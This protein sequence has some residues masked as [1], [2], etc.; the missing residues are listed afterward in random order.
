MSD[1]IQ[2]KSSL[3]KQTTSNFV[4]APKF[5]FGT[6]ER[7]AVQKV[8]LTHEEVLKQASLFQSKEM[9]TTFST[10]PPARLRPPA[11]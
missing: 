5:G 2:V 9:V 3:G 8:S 11:R 10:S 1:F 4:S 7:N 6:V